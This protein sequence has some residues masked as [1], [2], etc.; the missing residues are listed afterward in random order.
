[1][2]CQTSMNSLRTNSN[3]TPRYHE[4][5]RSSRV[6]SICHQR[7]KKEI[8]IHWPL[9]MRRIYADVGGVLSTISQGHKRRRHTRHSATTPPSISRL[10]PASAPHERQGSRV[11]NILICPPVFPPLLE[12]LSEHA[13]RK[14]PP[15]LHAP[16][17]AVPLLRGGVHTLP[18]PPRSR[19]A[20][21]RL[22]MLSRPCSHLSSSASNFS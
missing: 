18:Y 5:H 1:M 16:L 9:V 10:S 13:K 20:F 6:F 15:P 17:R 21:M 11:V 22:T 14:T 19:K 2:H 12:L 8:S 3:Q 4:A 7:S